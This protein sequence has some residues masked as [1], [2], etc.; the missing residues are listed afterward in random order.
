MGITSAAVPVIG[1]ALVGATMLVSY[2]IRNS[3]C[4]VT[5]VAILRQATGVP[6]PVGNAL[7]TS[8]S[9]LGSGSN[10]LLLGGLAVAVVLVMSLGGRR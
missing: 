8:L 6:V 9:T 1:A 7:T 5:C 4:G 2:L 3:G 10:I